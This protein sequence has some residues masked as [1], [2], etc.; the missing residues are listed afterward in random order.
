MRQCYIS[1]QPIISDHIETRL[2]EKFFIYGFVAA[3]FFYNSVS[4]Q[5]KS[6]VYFTGKYLFTG[7]AINLN[8]SESLM[9]WNIFGP[10]YYRGLTQNIQVGFTTSWLLSP[11]VLEMR[12]AYS[13][14]E[15]FH[16]GL[17]GMWGVEWI[18]EDP[19]PASLLSA[20][21]T[22]G[23]KLSNLSG[24]IYGV[25]LSDDELDS[26]VVFNISGYHKL[27]PRRAL[28]FES[29]I[30]NIDSRDKLLVLIPGMQFLTKRDRMLNVGI[31]NILYE[32]VFIL[33]P[34]PFLQL[35]VPF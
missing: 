32:D 18:D 29:F 30:V 2:M 13:I 1:I 26:G 12:G 27:N 11:V 21:I 20:T 8:Q 15:K 3:S 14:S 19:V 4:A 16:V 17:N 34:I 22:L 7:S 28:L 31:A 23:D 10:Q 33:V 25:E 6:E 5:E 24:T 35:Q 9:A